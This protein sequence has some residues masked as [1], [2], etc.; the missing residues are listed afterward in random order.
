MLF[1]FQKGGKDNAF[2]ASVLPRTIQLF[3]YNSY[4]YSV[5]TRF[6]SS[7]TDQQIHSCMNNSINLNSSL[8]NLLASPTSGQSKIGLPRKTNSYRRTLDLGASDMPSL[9]RS[10]SPINY[11]LEAYDEIEIMLDFEPEMDIKDLDLET[12]SISPNVE[13]LP[14]LPTDAEAKPLTIHTV[15]EAQWEELSQEERDRLMSEGLAA[16][17]GA[18]SS[19][20]IRRVFRYLGYDSDDDADTISDSSDDEWHECREGSPDPFSNSEY[21]LSDNPYTESEHEFADDNNFQSEGSDAPL[22]AGIHGHEEES[23]DS[24]PFYALTEDER[25]TFFHLGNIVRGL[26][27]KA[28][29]LPSATLAPDFVMAWRH[30]EVAMFGIAAE[31]RIGEVPVRIPV[32]VNPE[33]AP[34]WAQSAGT[35]S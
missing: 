7:S 3:I 27:H 31:V 29:T 9:S 13:E 15:A 24:R 22:F 12:R 28:E 4:L 16:A 6:H 35:V 34:Q 1:V 18:E 5:Q 11:D 8:H 21:E 20:H 25:D 17:A 30:F 2:V 33:T 26:E 14:K 19:G 23:E 10:A 32:L